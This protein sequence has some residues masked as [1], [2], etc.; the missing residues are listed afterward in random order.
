[1]SSAHVPAASPRKPAAIAGWLL[2]GFTAAVLVVAGISAYSMWDAS[3][4]SEA[5]WSLALLPWL[6][7]PAAICAL[8]ARRAG[9]EPEAWA[10]LGAEA[11]LVA[12][13]VC[14]WLVLIFIRPDP[15]NGI[16]MMAFPLLQFALLPAYVLG[17]RVVLRRRAA[18]NVS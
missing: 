17:V 3:E 4:P 12:S 9:S 10:F 1:M 2:V 5:A 11:A 13:T 18:Q 14:L 7:G 16:A 8:L 15:Q 6:A